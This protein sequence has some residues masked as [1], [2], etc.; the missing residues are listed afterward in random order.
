[1]LREG[2][3]GRRHRKKEKKFKEEE[4]NFQ[5]SQ[6]GDLRGVKCLQLKKSGAGRGQEDEKKGKK[7]K[8]W[9]ER[10]EGVMKGKTGQPVQLGEQ[11]GS[12]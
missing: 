11:R 9:K 7:V 1:M 8:N 4:D 12:R 5:H 3:R 6:H 10:R 2:G